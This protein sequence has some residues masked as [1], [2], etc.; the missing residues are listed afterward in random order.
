MIETYIERPK[1]IKAIQWTGKNKKEVQEFCPFTH[2]SYNN[3]LTI[4]GP[5]G[6][7]RLLEGDYIIQ[8][9]SGSYSYS[10]PNVFNVKYQKV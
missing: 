4:M 6:P 3:V 5:E 2:V 9:A 8:N 1:E 7:T 10:R